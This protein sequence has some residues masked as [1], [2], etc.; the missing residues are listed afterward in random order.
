MIRLD[1]VN[2]NAGEGG[3]LSFLENLGDVYVLNLWSNKKKV[4][5]KKGIDVVSG[6]CS[7]TKNERGRNDRHERGFLCHRGLQEQSEF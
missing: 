7:R 1:G 4:L 2:G 3:S 5:Q 6:L